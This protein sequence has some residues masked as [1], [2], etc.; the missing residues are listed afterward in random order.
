[1]CSDM[2]VQRMRSAV[3]SLKAANEEKVNNMMSC[4]FA[5]TITSTTC[6]HTII[7]QTLVYN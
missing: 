1:V 6:Q 5:V 3:E 2:E 7:S 4:Y